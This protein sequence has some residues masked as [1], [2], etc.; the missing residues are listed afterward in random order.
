MGT[1]NL[2]L[3]K[4]IVS[5]DFLT[6][7]VNFTSILTTVRFFCWLII[8]ELRFP[9][10]KS[11][12]YL[13]IVTIFKK[14]SLFL[15]PYI[16]PFTMFPYRGEN[17]WTF[18]YSLKS[19]TSCIKVLLSCHVLCSKKP[20]KTPKFWNPNYGNRYMYTHVHIPLTIRH[21][22]VRVFVFTCNLIFR[23]ML[24]HRPHPSF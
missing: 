12:Y 14:G 5:R 15:L 3:Y 11:K 20:C 4:V 23:N 21:M 10:Y 24:L 17:C 1:L 16:I 18:I 19:C 2:R 6:T 7:V 13:L 8:K 9:N 22:F